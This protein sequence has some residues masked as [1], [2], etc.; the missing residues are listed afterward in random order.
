MSFLLNLF[1]NRV[2]QV[3]LTICGLDKAGK[4]TLVNYLIHG[5]FRDTIPTSGMNREVLNFPK[6][7]LD[8]FD[9]G[10]QQEFRPMWSDYNEQ[11]DGLIFVVDSSD[12]ARLSESKEIFHSI[13]DTQINEQIPVLILL[14]KVDLPDRFE[15]MEFIKKFGLNDPDLE[16]DWAIFETSAVT[17]EG[18]LDAFHWLVNFFEEGGN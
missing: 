10:G 6:L 3:N 7:Q 2:K 15:L 12:K 1:K 16:I 9:L 17:G 5:E 11:S 4:T 8:I 18:V 13:I 14:H